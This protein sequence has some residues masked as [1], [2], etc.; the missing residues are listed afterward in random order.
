MVNLLFD[1]SL[2][3]SHQMTGLAMILNS[4]MAT[5]I[6]AHSSSP[7]DPTTAMRGAASVVSSQQGQA[8]S[9]VQQSF[10]GHG[11]GGAGTLTGPAVHG[12]GER[13]S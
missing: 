3:Q 1:V 13:K 4:L 11:A 2:L 5:G 10:Y 8:H 7:V 12:H 9:P 6:N